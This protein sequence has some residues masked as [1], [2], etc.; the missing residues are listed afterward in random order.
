M[1]EGPVGG[2]SAMRAPAV[3]IFLL[4]TFFTLVIVLLSIP[5]GW[6]SVYVGPLGKGNASSISR[7]YFWIGPAFFFVPF[8]VT[9]GFAFLFLSIIYVAMLAYA[10]KQQVSLLHASRMSLY[11]GFGA[12]LSSP[13]AV[14]LVGTGFLVFGGSVIDDIVSSAG[15]PIGSVTGDPLALLLGFTLS[16]LIEEIGFRVVLIGAIAFILSLH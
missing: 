1:T 2:G 11:E 16:P 10:A 5:A 4:L 12:L 6:Y 14:V 15:A 7:P 9:I 3:M 13:L 8:S